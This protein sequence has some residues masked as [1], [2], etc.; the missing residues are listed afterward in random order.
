MTGKE[1]AAALGISGAMVSR[2]IRRGMPSDDIDRAMRWRRRHLQVGRMK[3]VRRGTEKTPAQTAPA[4]PLALATPGAAETTA[5]TSDLD[6]ERDLFPDEDPDEAPVRRFTEARDRKE[7]YQAE[8]A[9]L[10]YEKQCGALM[11]AGEVGRA[12][13]DAATLLR[14]SLEALPAKMAH[15]LAALPDEGAMEA[16]LADEIEQAL[17]SISE[18]FA[19]LAHRED[20]AP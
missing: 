7:F 16:A 11:P 6:N 2:L 4:A 1:L 13:A 8:L 5:P 14:V 17:H 12:V 3:G 10:E 9:R 20:G 19:S 15:R 18:A